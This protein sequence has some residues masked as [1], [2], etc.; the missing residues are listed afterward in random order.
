M[1]SPKA[2]AYL[3]SPAVVAASAVAGYICGPY[4]MDTCEP[5]GSVAI[6]PPPPRGPT[7]VPLVDGFPSILSGEVRRA[8]C[9]TPAQAHGPLRSGADPPRGRHSPQSHKP[10]GGRMDATSSS[11]ATRTT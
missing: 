7:T 1:G 5:V 6:A 10:T 9:P 4:V 11:F 3:A 2:Q 8:T